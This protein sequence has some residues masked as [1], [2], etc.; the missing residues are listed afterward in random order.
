MIC[1]DQIKKGG[2][3]SSICRLCCVLLRSLYQRKKLVY[4]LLDG[5]ALQFLLLNASGKPAF[6]VPMPLKNTMQHCII[7]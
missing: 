5:P 7:K 4:G 6:S 3:T 1:P 2:S